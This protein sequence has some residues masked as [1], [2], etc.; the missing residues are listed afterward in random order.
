MIEVL[1]GEFF[2]AA[3]VQSAVAIA[4]HWWAGRVAA[5]Q[6]TRF[7]RRAR[8]LPMVALG[9]ALT[10]IATC[11]ALLVRA[12]GAVAV[13]DPATKATQ[14]A[15]SISMAM[16]CTALFLIPTA[17]CYLASIAISIVGTLKEGGSSRPDR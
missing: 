9:L 3:A 8:V 17:L 4:L 2:L 11:M 7:Y 16:N 15:Q 1:V 13:A 5:R 14:L 10:G 12:F 6:E